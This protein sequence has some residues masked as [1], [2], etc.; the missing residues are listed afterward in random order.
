MERDSD[1]QEAMEQTYVARTPDAALSLAQTIE[2]QLQHLLPYTDRDDPPSGKD[3]YDTP[4]EPR[5]SLYALMTDGMLQDALLEKTVPRFVEL[6][7]PPLDDME[8]GDEVLL[9]VHSHALDPFSIWVAR[10]KIKQITDERRL[11][12]DSVKHWL[13]Q[14]MKQILR[15]M[16]GK[17][18]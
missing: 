15:S 13:Q 11:L 12:V 8:P 6:S 10:N 17:R 9:E 18:H 3:A 14:T 5:I 4:Y 1:E 16:L 7:G 2:L